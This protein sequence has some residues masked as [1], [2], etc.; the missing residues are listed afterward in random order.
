MQLLPSIGR[1][2]FSILLAQ[3]LKRSC[4]RRV[5][6]IHAL[7]NLNQQ[8]HQQRLHAGTKQQALHR[9]NRRCSAAINGGHHG[10][11]KEAGY[12]Q[13]RHANLASNVPIGLCDNVK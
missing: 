2:T 4:R 7:Y 3:R 12:L 8:P 11:G 6:T 9:R 10:D 5:W 1:R 13:R